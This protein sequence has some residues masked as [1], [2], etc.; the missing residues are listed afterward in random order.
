MRKVVLLI[1][2]GLFGG[3]I[4]TCSGDKLQTLNKNNEGLNKQ[5]EYNPA[6]N[7]GDFVSKVDNKYFTLK[8]GTKFVYENKTDEGVERIE[9]VITNETREIQGVKT[10]EVRDRVWVNNELIEDTRDWYAQDK[11]GNVW[12][13][14]E[15][16]DN[17]RNGKVVNHNGAW[18]GGVDGAKPGIIMKAHPK[19]GDSYRQEYYSGKA[20]DMADVVALDKKVTV[21]GRTFEGCLQ[22]RDW[23]KIEKGSE[24]KYY[25]PEVGFVVLEESGQERIELVD[26]SNN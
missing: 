12:Y 3:F 2:L 24:H 7:P 17:Y 25:C 16:V 9:V 20:E 5:L 22:T 11:D 10:M 26:I 13:F 8:P 15:A 19:V 14:G 21:R 18:E 6:I 4:T 1:V 23:S